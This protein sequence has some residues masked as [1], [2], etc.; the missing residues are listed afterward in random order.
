L[1]FNLQWTIF[2]GGARKNRVAQAQAE[3]HAGEARVNVKRNQ[4]ADQVWQMFTL[5]DA[6]TWWAIGNFREGQLKWITPGMKADVYVMSRP[7]CALLEL[8]IASGLA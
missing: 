5:I 6:R 2:D 3:V 7:T 4:I 8:W 1:R